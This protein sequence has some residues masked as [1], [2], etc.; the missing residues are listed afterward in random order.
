MLDPPDRLNLGSLGVGAK[1]TV[2]LVLSSAAVALH[3]VLVTTVTR[4][5]VAHKATR[6]RQIKLVTLWIN[7]VIIFTE[8]CKVCIKKMNLRSTV[9]LHGSHLIAHPAHGLQRWVIV[10]Q[11]KLMTHHVLHLVDSHAALLLVL[12]SEEKISLDWVERRF[13]SPCVTMNV[14]RS[15]WAW[16]TASS[17]CDRSCCHCRPQSEG[18]PPSPGRTAARGS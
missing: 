7:I 5:L 15:R 17:Q 9:D 18:S 4:V 12:Y 16:K 11:L 14:Q 13:S 3:D 2:T 6:T 1:L 10:T 8:A